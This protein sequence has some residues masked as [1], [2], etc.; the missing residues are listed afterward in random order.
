LTP[1]TLSETPVYNT[2]RKVQKPIVRG[3]FSQ[4]LT[5]I[6]SRFSV[7]AENLEG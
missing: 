3:S 6:R 7:L 1:P 2:Y 5:M 4:V